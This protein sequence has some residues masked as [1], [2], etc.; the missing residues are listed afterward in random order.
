MAAPP[1]SSNGAMKRER[2]G[3]ASG[4]NEGIGKNGSCAPASSSEPP[5]KPAS[6]WRD[7]PR[8]LATVALGVPTIILSLRNPVTSWLFFQG[9]HILCIIEWR[10]LVPADVSEDAPSTVAGGAQKKRGALQKLQA[11]IF[12]NTSTDSSPLSMRMFHLFAVFSMLIAILPTSLLPLAYMSH[13]IAARL[14][15]HLPSFQPHPANATEMQHYQFGLLYLSAGFHFLLQISSVGG[16]IHIGNLLFIVWMSDTGALILGRAMKKRRDATRKNER[17]GIFSAFLKSVSPGKTLPG[18][19]GAVITGP[20][21][22]MI[23]PVQLSSSTTVAEQCNEGGNA[24]TFAILHH[25]LLQKAALGLAISL[26]GIVGDLAE[27]AVKRLS[28]KKD[29]GGLLPGHGGVVD[30]FDSLFVAGVV[31][32]YWLLA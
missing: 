17:R 7:L 5:P 18:L 14:L 1:P 22:A 20:I 25:P 13:G 31:Y 26:A 24:T 28:R 27:S 8:R 3:D 29:S 19:W 23:Y 4:K 16:P 12:I 11:A 30:R 15:P 6:A 10:A 21:C 2:G 32:Y 9:A